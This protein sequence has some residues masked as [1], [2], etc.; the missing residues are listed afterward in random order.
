MKARQDA[1]K[2]IKSIVPDGA[3]DG[4]PWEDAPSP[5]MDYDFD[6][7]KWVPKS[8]KEEK[9]RMLEEEFKRNLEMLEDTKK[10][11]SASTKDNDSTEQQ[12]HQCTTTPD[13]PKKKVAATPKKKAK[14]RQSASVSKSQKQAHPLEVL[15]TPVVEVTQDN[16][17]TEDSTVSQSDPVEQTKKS[18]RSAKMDE[19]DF[20]V[21]ADRFI[22]PTDLMEKKPLFFPEA[23]RESLRTIAALIPGGK[24]SP[25]HVA[26]LIVTSWIDEH[27]DLLNRMLANKKSSI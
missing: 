10:T 9:K 1:E 17:R 4:N 6:I 11:D 23:L 7:D 19:A 8:F 2:A 3:I 5:D 21:L 20:A 27:R 16:P 24:V 18:R 26:I 15:P 25:S 12:V 13:A 14:P 22:H